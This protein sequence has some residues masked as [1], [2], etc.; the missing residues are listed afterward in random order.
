MRNAIRKTL[1]PRQFK[2]FAER[3][4]LQVVLDHDDVVCILTGSLYA[5]E[6]EK[7]LQLI[8]A[9]LKTAACTLLKGCYY[10]RGRDYSM[11]VWIGDRRIKCKLSAH[12]PN[13]LN[14][15]LFRAFN[16][17]IW[18]WYWS[19]FII[20]SRCTFHRRASLLYYINF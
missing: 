10:T 13:F 20:S 9:W 17:F 12:G 11:R 2:I 5:G 4:D 18:L 7:K 16:G 1:V 6:Q 3:P 19:C 15:F 8:A 14:E